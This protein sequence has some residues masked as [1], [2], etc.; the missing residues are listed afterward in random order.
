MLRHPDN[1][2]LQMDQVTRLY[3]PARYDDHLAVYQDDGQVF[4]VEG[5]ISI[6]EDPNFRFDFARKDA[7]T[8]R[9]E[10]S[11]IDNAHFEASW[12]LQRKGS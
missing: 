2:G 8:L 7:H 11:D 4:S 3:T 1:S 6:S 9:V 12:P 10:A 5:G